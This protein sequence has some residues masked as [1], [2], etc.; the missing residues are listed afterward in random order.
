MMALFRH[1][2]FTAAER[3]R[4]A[5]FEG[6]S[7]TLNSRIF[8]NCVLASEDEISLLRNVCRGKLYGMPAVKR[9]LSTYHPSCL[10]IKML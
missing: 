7:A 4:N 9:A 2:L 10:K 6:H 1:L 8:K 3:Q 5:G